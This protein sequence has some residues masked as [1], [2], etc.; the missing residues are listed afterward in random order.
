MKGIFRLAFMGYSLALT[1]LQVDYLCNKFNDYQITPFNNYTLFQAKINTCT[2]TIYKT[3]TLLIQGKNEEL[4]YQE[5][6]NDLNI[7]SKIKDNPIKQQINNY[8]IQ[9]LIGTDEVGTGDFFGGI[10]VAGA[11]VSKDKISLIK[12]LGVKDSKALTDYKINQIAPVIMKTI[13]YTVFKLD[14]LKFNFL[15]IQ[16][17]YNM[18]QIKALLHNTVI[19]AMKQKV[20]IYDGIIIDAFTTS[21]NYF[22]YLKNE[23]NVARDVILEEKAEN[24]Y[25]SVACASII[26]RYEFL[27]MM[28]ELSE[29]VGFELPKGAGKPV[30][31]AIKKIFMEKGLNGFKNIAKIKFKNLDIYR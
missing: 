29:L 8:I 31:T 25:L 11:F 24:K 9:S 7:E 30:D 2:I 1:Q 23:R 19:N 28:D 20:K 18:N 17:K 22:N 13:P 12:K 27:K 5:I 14:C 21:S 15:S 6:C 10:V 4:L 16:K 3:N 26:A